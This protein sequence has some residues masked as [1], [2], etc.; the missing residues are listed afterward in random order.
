VSEEEVRRLKIE[1]DALAEAK[2]AAAKA[3]DDEKAETIKELD[4]PKRK[5]EQVQAS[6]DLVQDENDKLTSADQKYNV[7]EAE[8]ERL[9]TEL[10]A[11][12]EA[13]AGEF[14]AEKAQVKKESDDL[15]TKLE[16]TQACKDLLEGEID[17]LRPEAFMTEKKSSLF[18]EDEAGTG[19]VGGGQGGVRC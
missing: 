8:V 7:S 14:E 19:R 11:L 12:E 13:A 4:G 3:F 15:K 5:V 9:K 2:D 10:G 1:L 18:E 6:K 16:E 17:K